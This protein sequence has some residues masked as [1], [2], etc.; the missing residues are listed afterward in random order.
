MSTKGVLTEEVAMAFWRRRYADDEPLRA[1]LEAYELALDEAL[2]RAVEEETGALLHELWETHRA[3]IV[4]LPLDRRAVYNELHAIARH[5]EAGLLNL[6]ETIAVDVPAEALD[7]PDHLF[8]DEQGRFRAKLNKWEHAVIEAERRRSSFVTWVRNFDRKPWSLA[9]PYTLGGERRPG[10]PDFIVVRRAPNG[11]LVV[12]LL[13][14]H[15]G[16]DSV[17]K[18]A[19]LAGFADRH[20]HDFGRIEMIRIEDGRIRRLDMNDH[21]TRQAVLPIQT[22]DE[23][24][25]LFD[26]EG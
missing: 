5:E 17:A 8:V 15:Q 3:A 9:Y 16:A 23:L 11:A 21:R 1:K 4:A 14:P 18:A 6:P 22:A 25:R 12:D 13:E 7:C 20:G 10:H 24:T 19:G 2:W 26:R